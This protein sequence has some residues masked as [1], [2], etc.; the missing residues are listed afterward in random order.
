MDYPFCP[1]FMSPRTQNIAANHL[2]VTNQ[3]PSKLRPNEQANGDRGSVS[4]CTNL[5]H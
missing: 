5:R 2:H 1:E 3:L 4:G